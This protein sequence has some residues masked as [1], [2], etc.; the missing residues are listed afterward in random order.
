MCYMHVLYVF[1]YI[2]AS[3]QFQRKLFNN[4]ICLLTVLTSVA[5]LQEQVV[6]Y[7][8]LAGRLSRLLTAVVDVR[9]RGT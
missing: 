1:F 6:I 5:N 2:T 8:M 4:C 9:W 7:R 3:W